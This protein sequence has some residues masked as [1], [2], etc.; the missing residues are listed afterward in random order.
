MY[1]A[2]ATPRDAAHLHRPEHLPIRRNSPIN[3]NGP[4]T[5]A[6]RMHPSHLEC[7]FRHLLAHSLYALILGPVRPISTPIPMPHITKTCQNFCPS[8]HSNQAFDRP[9][10][11]KT[12]PAAQS[13]KAAIQPAAPRIRAMSLRDCC[14]QG[15]RDQPLRQL[16]A[17]RWAVTD[18]CPNPLRSRRI[19]NQEEKRQ[20]R[21]RELAWLE[22]PQ[23]HPKRWRSV[24]SRWPTPLHPSLGR[25]AS[26]PESGKGAGEWGPVAAATRFPLCRP[27][28]LAPLLNHHPTTNI[29]NRTRTP[30]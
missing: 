17:D 16:A 11:E 20:T 30:P 27:L 7:H 12:S 5:N 23:E 25:P 15:R 2:P 28:D 6:S 18:H 8:C 22:G 21:N 19:P 10:P 1:I 4:T 14:I 3:R 26:S 29:R 9:C 24:Q 13:E